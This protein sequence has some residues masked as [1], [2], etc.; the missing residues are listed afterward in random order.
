MSLFALFLLGLSLAADACVIAVSNSIAF[1]NARKQIFITALCFALAQAVMPVLGY[2]LGKSLVFLVGY[3]DHWIAIVLLLVVGGKMCIEGISIA[4]SVLLPPAKPLT[5][6]LLFTQAIATSIDAF[7]VGLSFSAMQVSI[8]LAALL[9]GLIT[10]L[11]C[12]AGGFAGRRFGHYL[13]RYAVF[14]GGCIL[15]LLAAKI[16][17][18][19]LHLIPF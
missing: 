8:V 5:P 6:W 12:L 14:A 16:L 19:H 15:L 17:F 3:W 13:Q 2:F 9:I 10:F 11:C 7:A 1:A 18:S 4:R